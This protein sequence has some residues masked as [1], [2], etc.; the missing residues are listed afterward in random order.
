MC[1][2][3]VVFFRTQFIGLKH[4]DCII[5]ESK[6]NHFESAVSKLVS[7]ALQL[8]PRHKTRQRSHDHWG[9]CCSRA[10]WSQA[11]HSSC[12]QVATP[13]C[14]CTWCQRH[15]PVDF[16]RSW[17]SRT[18]HQQRNLWPKHEKFTQSVVKH[19]KVAHSL[20]KIFKKNNNSVNSV[21]SLE[22]I[23][24]HKFTAPFC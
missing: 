6:F 12:S 8:S 13:G 4:E 18:I 23:L 16:R 15:L 14:K 20:V 1:F 5:S 22:T 10:G 7:T 2:S 11:D 24:L 17:P 21:S 9:R 19:E 3:V